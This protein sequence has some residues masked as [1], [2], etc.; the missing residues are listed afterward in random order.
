MALSKPVCTVRV[1]VSPLGLGLGH[2]GVEAVDVAHPELR[3]LLIAIFHLAH[4]PAQGNDRLLRVG[5]DGGKQ[6]RDSVI[7]G[8]LEHL[9]ID[10]D[11]AAFFRREPVEPATGSWC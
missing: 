10:H 8:E 2:A 7:D 3:H 1:M 5:D 6:V 9:G 4:R 11:Q